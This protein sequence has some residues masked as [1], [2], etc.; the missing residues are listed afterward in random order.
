MI[1]YLKSLPSWLGQKRKVSRQ[2][3]RVMAEEGYP[4]GSSLA[5]PF[6]GGAGI[7]M[8][9]KALGYKVQANDMSPFSFAVGK[10]LIENAHR[11]ISLEER[12]LAMTGAYGEAKLPGGKDLALSKPCRLI[13]AKM[14][15]A[16]RA[17]EDELLKHLYGAWIG[18]TTLTMAMW[19]I[20]TMAAGLRDWDEMTVGQTGQLKKTGRPL[21]T[22]IKVAAQING[23]V[24]DNGYENTMHRGDAVEWLTGVDAET[25]VY[26]DPP[27]PGTLSYEVVYAGINRMLDPEAS[28]KPSKWS[29]KDGWRLLSDAL[30]AAEASPLWVVSMGKQADPDEMVEM[31]RKRGRR[32]DWRSIDHKHLTSI[33]KTHDEGGDELLIIGRA[34][35]QK[36][37]R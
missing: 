15:A 14:L 29:A 25:V 18:K 6:M 22:A 11:T 30:D 16:E 19:G 5:D 2:I 21:Q 32:A 4:A 8:A 28:T 17:T 20:P 3:M 33:K 27:Y 34:K 24:F 26:L 23:G 1:D 36:G 31:M 13:L 12:D 7:S 9:A 35:K 37:K 10:A